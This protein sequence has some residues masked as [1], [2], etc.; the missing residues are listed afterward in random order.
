MRSFRS[1]QGDGSSLVVLKR[2]GL[3]QAD[4]VVDA[5]GLLAQLLALRQV[6]QQRRRARRRGRDVER[7]QGIEGCL[8][9]DA[10]ARAAGELLAAPGQPAAMSAA[11]SA[12]VATASP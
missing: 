6:A 10:A 11:P 9:A 4:A 7:V 3:E 2:A 5:L 1:L 12:R 8:A